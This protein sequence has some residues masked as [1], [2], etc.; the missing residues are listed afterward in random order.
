MLE[1]IL[2]WLDDVSKQ[3]LML[4]PRMCE[5]P[6]R[7]LACESVDAAHHLM[8]LFLRVKMLDCVSWHESHFSRNTG[9]RQEG[10]WKLSTHQSCRLPTSAS[11]RRDQR[12]VASLHGLAV[13]PS[14][15]RPRPFH[16]ATARSSQ[17]HYIAQAR[18][19]PLG[20]WLRRS[21]TSSVPVLPASESL[22]FRRQ[23][24]TR[25]AS[26]GE[27]RRYQSDRN[28]GRIRSGLFDPPSFGEPRV[29]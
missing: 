8:Q 27:R 19:L 13:A 18:A 15:S 2:A 4:F 20:A 5:F 26:S 21:A 29:S 17:A 22:R 25:S 14:P 9:T 24:P 3:I 1:V 6:R 12:A 11:Q 16:C 28:P 7:I 23:H 10:K